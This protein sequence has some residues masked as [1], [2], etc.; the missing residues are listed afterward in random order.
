MKKIE[1]TEA[2]TDR[3]IL[4]CFDVMNELRTQ[5]KRE[6]FLQTV[7]AMEVDGYRLAFVEDEGV[8]VAAAG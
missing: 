8:V 5:L 7:R 3:E 2:K 6:E 1:V 4:S